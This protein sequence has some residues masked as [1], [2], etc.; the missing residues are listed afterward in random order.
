MEEIAYPC[1]RSARTAL[2]TA[3]RVTPRVLLISAPEM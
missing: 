1:S 3:M 2:L